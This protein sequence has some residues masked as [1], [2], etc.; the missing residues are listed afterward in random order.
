MSVN[1]NANKIKKRLGLTQGGDVQRFA[2][3]TC[4]IHMDKYVPMDNGTLAENVIEQPDRIIY[5]TPYA[6]YMYEGILYVDPDY[7]YGAI[8]IKDKEGNVQGFYS[9]KGITK[10]PSGKSL[11][12]DT[13]K[14]AYAGP[15]W[16]ERM[17][18]AERKEVI[19]EIQDYI[20]RK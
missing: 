7:G 4:R 14:H 15:K 8:P 13:S 5:N 11:Q 6:H 2:V 10:V 19:K 16:D 17:W 20:R 1:I 9:R 12:Y 18:S 3:Q